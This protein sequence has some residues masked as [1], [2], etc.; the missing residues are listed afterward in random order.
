MFVGTRIRGVISYMHTVSQ[1]KGGAFVSTQAEMADVL[2][3]QA[4]VQQ[5]R[6]VFH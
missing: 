4:W 1:K 5:W 6:N 3:N 2:R